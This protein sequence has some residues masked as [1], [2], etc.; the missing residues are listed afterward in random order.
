MQIRQSRTCFTSTPFIIPSWKMGQKPF[1]PFPYKFTFKCPHLIRKKSVHQ[2]K[3]Q[4]QPQQIDTQLMWYYTDIFTPFPSLYKHITQKLRPGE[5]PDDKKVKCS[6]ELCH[7]S[8]M[9]PNLIT[10]NHSNPLTSTIHNQHQLLHNFLYI[11][12][13][14]PWWKPTQ[15]K[16]LTSLCY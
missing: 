16:T 5:L 8:E 12:Y 9:F 1:H 6:P 2:R 4:I 3:P 7:L 11:L 14:S 13:T 15:K 10:A